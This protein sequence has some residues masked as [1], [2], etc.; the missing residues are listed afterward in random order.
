MLKINTVYHGNTLELIKQID[1]NSIDLIICDGPYGVSKHG[2]DKVGSIQE[3]NLNL[4]ELFTPKLKKGGAVYLFGKEDCID[5]IDYKKYLN[6]QSKIVWYQPSRLR[7]G[8]VNYTNCYDLICY[9]I[10]G[11]KPKTFNLDDI[12]IPQVTSKENMEKINN[13]HKAVHGANS[14]AQFN[15]NGK[16]PG[17][18]WNDVGQ[19][20]YN[21]KELISKDLSTIQKPM[22][23]IERLVLASSN[24]GDLILDPFVGTGTCP[25]VCKELQRNFVGFEL[26]PKF[27]DITNE[28]LS[29]PYQARLL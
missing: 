10:K 1:D 23:L 17:N 2:W 18:L 14:K 15:P 26:D 3:Y 25:L 9:F 4:I 20:V 29:K 16:N 7:Q 13:F 6:L 12:R 5:F 19:L 11:G 27:F 21:S 8:K 22:K 24:K 28:R